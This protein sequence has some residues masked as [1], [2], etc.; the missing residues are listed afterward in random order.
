[1][2][3]AAKVLLAVFVAATCHGATDSL[4]YRSPD[5]AFSVMNV[6]DSAYPD[7]YFEIRDRNGHVLLASNSFP[8][9]ESGSFASS[10]R[11]SPDS[12]F[13]A[14]SVLT[15][16]PYLQDAFVYSI[17]DRSLLRILTKEVDY[18]TTPLRWIDPHTLI[19]QSRTPVGGKASDDRP[20]YRFR[21]TV[22]LSSSPLRYKVIDASPRSIE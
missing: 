10:I 13:V 3:S 9:L 18:E 6:G 1:M 15:S 11:W 8:S 19:L 12:A 2:N 7:H 5:G 20:T 14:F 16:G 17:G 22:R 4:R 21:R